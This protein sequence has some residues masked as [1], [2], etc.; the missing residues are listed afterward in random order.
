MS[1]NGRLGLDALVG[2]LFPPTCLLCG[3]PGADGRDLCRGCAADLPRNINACARCALPFAAPSPAGA[4]CGRCQR[5]APPFDRCLAAFR[6]EGVVPTLVTDVKFRGRLN[7][8]RLLGQCLAEGARS[9]ETTL[10]SLLIPVP[11]HPRRQRERGY[12]QALEIARIVGRELKIPVAADR[13]IR[14]MATP[15][16]TG[17]DERERHRNIRGAFAARGDLTGVDLAI[18]DDVVTTG[19]TVS[20]L[21]RILNAAGAQR[22]EVWAVA[23]TP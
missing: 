8:A 20:E 1:G 2:L 15:P 12:N 4:L 22:I 13:C 16:Q 7:V 18:I 14:A 10:P 9:Q 6:Y 5:R 19:S 11:L 21:S 3:A 23:R 17:L